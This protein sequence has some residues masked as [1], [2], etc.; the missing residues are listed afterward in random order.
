[1]SDAPL[2]V[3]IYKSKALTP[4]EQG[5]DLE[6]V[7]EAVAFNQPND[8]SGF[9]VRYEGHY[10]QVI[11]GEEQKIIGL[12]ERIQKDERH[13]ESELLWKGT[14]PTRRFPAWAMSYAAFAEGFDADYTDKVL[15]GPLKDETE[16][17]SILEGFRNA[18]LAKQANGTLVA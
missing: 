13:S 14:H 18:I 16:V 5:E 7:S 1:M 4:I 6:I 3:L 2:T 9:L 10:I 12:W 17:E 8:I 11:E 15:A